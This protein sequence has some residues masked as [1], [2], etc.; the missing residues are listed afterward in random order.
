VV[1]GKPVGAPSAATDDDAM[2]VD[3]QMSQTDG[4]DKVSST[5]YDVVGVIR[6]RLVFNTRPKTL[7][8]K[9]DPS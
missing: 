8:F 5:Y 6:K 9:K 2:D 7:L 4:E 3:E 1:D